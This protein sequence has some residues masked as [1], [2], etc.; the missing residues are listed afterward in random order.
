MKTVRL[1]ALLLLAAPITVVAG[2]YPTAERVQFVLECMQNHGAKDEYL[3]KCSCVID[4][5][6]KKLGYDEYVETSTALRGQSASGERGAEFRDPEMVKTMAKK[7][8]M[9]QAVANKA[10]FVP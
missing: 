8:K 7:F 6:A 4:R 10:C 9:V 2:E 1:L 5:I 3:Y